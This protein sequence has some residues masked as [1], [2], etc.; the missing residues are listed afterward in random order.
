MF[1]FFFFSCFYCD[2]KS[3]IHFRIV[4]SFCPRC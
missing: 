3:F 1:Y 4:F 2:V